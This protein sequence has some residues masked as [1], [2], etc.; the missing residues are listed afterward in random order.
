MPVRAWVIFATTLVNRAGTMVLPFLVL[1]IT[2][3]LGY[4]AAQAGFALTIYGIGGLISAPVAGRLSDRISPVHVMQF[5]LLTAGTL[6]LVLPLARS[7]ALVFALILLWSVIGEA[8]RPSSLA[9]LTE[10]TPP[11]QRKAV[12][13]LNRLAINLGMSI[14][15]AVGGFLAATS[16]YLLFTID[17]ATSI[18]AA[19]LLAVLVRR[20][21][22]PAGSGTAA[23]EAVRTAGALRDPRMLRFMLAFV[24][25][26]AMFFQIEAAL[27]LFIV[28]DLG[29]PQSFFG[30]LFS[31]NTALVIA[32][33][34]PLNLATAGWPHRRALV[35]ATL[36]MSAG[37]GA[38]AFATTRWSIVL[39][40]VV[41]TFGE[42]MLF[43]VAATYVADL[44]PA[45]R[46]G[47]YMGSY[48]IAL[49]F[50]RMVGP[51]GGTL[52][53]DRFGAPVLWTA[54][55]V[56]G[57]CAAATFGLVVKNEVLQRAA[58]I[59]ASSGRYE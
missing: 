47:E 41:L 33:E 19:L 9:A 39:P 43:P 12:V 7:L 13:A 35:L 27:A 56:C 23:V 53:L 22:L 2:Q 36:V 42:M 37:F 38:F 59:G 11:H 28:R 51:W 29:L 17:G 16:F 4:S 15:P 6:L 1:Y 14:G 10:S 50:A 34:I 24:L 21:P 44:A 55:F 46:R 18:V 32:F 30:L 49:S 52:V 40:L 8:V 26:G 5:S 45:E 3:E 20:Q 58:E 48:W 25:V 31:L 57:L 54:V